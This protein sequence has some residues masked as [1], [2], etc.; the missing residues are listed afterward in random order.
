MNVLEFIHKMQ[1]NKVSDNQLNR[2]NLMFIININIK[3][4]AFLIFITYFNFSVCI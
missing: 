1:V 4:N 2:L 3:L